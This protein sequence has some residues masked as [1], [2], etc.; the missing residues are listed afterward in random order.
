VSLRVCLEL[1]SVAA[2]TDSFATG[3]MIITAMFYTRTE[4]GERV[5]W[6]VRKYPP[7]PCP[8]LITRCRTFQCNGFAQIVSGFISFGV[9]HTNAK[10]HPSQW[11]WI[12]VVLS[13]ATF[14]TG[15]LYAWRFPNNPPTARFLSEADKIKTIHRVQANQNG[16]ET[17]V[18]K[19]YQCVSLWYAQSI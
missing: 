17:K 1:P 16:I 10:G 4:I 8:I 15:C 6:L 2:Y 13:I 11:Q 19:K 14:F 7:R 5:G 9:V 3:L 12:M 18:W